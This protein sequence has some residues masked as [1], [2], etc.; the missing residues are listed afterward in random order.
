M[1]AGQDIEKNWWTD[2]AIQ[3]PKGLLLPGVT[4]EE[5]A[6]YA[7]MKGFGPEARSSIGG[8]SQRLDWSPAKTRTHQQSLW[9]KGWITL[10]SGG[11][12]GTPRQWW[13]G[14]APGDQPPQELV[15]RLTKTMRLP[16]QAYEN[17]QGDEKAA[18]G[19]PLPQTNNT[20]QTNNDNSKQA[21]K[22]RGKHPEQDAFWKKAEATWEAKHPGVKL[23]WPG[24]TGFP[25]ALWNA[26]ETL[27]AD[28]LARRWE[29]MVLDPFSRPSMMSLCKDP[30]A[31]VAR[32]EGKQTP[33]RA[34]HAPST[35][36]R[37]RA[38]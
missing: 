30:N 1:K 4:G 2:K 29:N 3:I 33:A 21:T 26:L 27:K 28:E 22:G 9:K 12:N 36:W 24:L 10:I 35:D 11:T 32:R 18:P 25:T 17:H 8:L 34:F 31:W 14:S 19:K 5:L 20:N 37:P 16:P 15:S 38:N 7:K 13:M 6:V 23:E